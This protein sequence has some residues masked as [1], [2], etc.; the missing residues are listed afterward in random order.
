MS[1][2]TLSGVVS[3]DSY[4]SIARPRTVTEAR[5]RLALL[6]AFCCGLLVSLVIELAV[7]APTLVREASARTQGATVAARR[8][9]RHRAARVD[10]YLD[11]VSVELDD[12]ASLPPQAPQA[13][14]RRSA[15]KPRPVPPVDGAA[16]LDDALQP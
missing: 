15:P 14:A 5:S 12:G 2:S 1:H 8:L 9:P 3:Y 11:H 6:F 4:A 16:L 10:R 7:R 13:A